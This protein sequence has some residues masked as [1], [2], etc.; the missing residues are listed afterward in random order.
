M[1]CLVFLN[2]CFSHNNSE[3]DKYTENITLKLS[4][5]LQML[6]KF[7]YGILLQLH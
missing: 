4:H 7:M 6:H 5:S 2:I 3:L 1:V